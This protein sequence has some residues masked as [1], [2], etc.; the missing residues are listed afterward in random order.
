MV[1]GVSVVRAG[2][3]NRFQGGSIVTAHTATGFVRSLRWSDGVMLAI[4]TPVTTF[5]LIGLEIGPIGAWGALAVWCVTS[6]VALVQNLIYAELALLL[7]DR[8]GGIGVFAHEAWRRYATPLGALAVFG[9]WA[10]WSVTLAVCGLQVGRLTQAEWF[11]SWTGTISLGGG[12]VGLPH[13]IAAAMILL[14]YVLNV[15]GIALVARINR[16][17]SVLLA[18]LGAVCLIGPF[19]V[20]PI[21]LSRLHWHFEG[22]GGL[23]L[24]QAF[25]VWSFI[26]SW[27]SY[28]TELCATFAPEYHNPRDH[29]RWA[30][31]VS[32]LIVILVAVLSC[33]VLPSVVGEQAIGDDPIGFYVAVVD[34]IIGHGLTGVFIAVI[35]LA[36]FVTMNSAI[37]GS[38]RA[39]HGLAERGLTV[40]QLDRLN[41]RGV[42]ARAMVVDLVVNIFIVFFIANITGII[43]AGNIG[44]ILSVILALGG[45]MILRRH[46]PDQVPAICRGRIWTGIAILLVAFNLA[47]IGVGFLHPAAAGYGGHM[48]QIVAVAILVC[49]LLLF[50]YR[51]GV[52]DTDGLRL[53]EA[54]V[55]PEPGITR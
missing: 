16:I 51:R 44:Y 28:G 41:A 24:W 2:S 19:F 9:Y 1:R 5:C 34:R 12:A 42:P 47:M 11:P 40:R 7:P 50:F 3:G 25:L 55:L 22:T 31:V 17:V 45:F 38:S 8:S 14:V 26:T 43:F 4:G 39:L 13:V 15:R 23:P 30:L 18:L 35:C 29:I 48:Q 49:S 20:V 6:L 53:R 36:Q 21:D 27:T 10:G 52:Q 37:A 32:S 46:R 54:D 33:V